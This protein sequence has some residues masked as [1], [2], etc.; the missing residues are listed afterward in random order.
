MKYTILIPGNE[1][2]EEQLIALRGEDSYFKGNIKL[3]KG[4]Y[5]LVPE[6]ERELL[7][8]DN[9]DLQLIGYEGKPK[10]YGTALLSSMGYKAEVLD[11]E[12]KSW[13]NDED[14][15]KV[16]KIADSKGKSTLQHC[17]SREISE[18]DR[19]YAINVLSNMFKIIKEKIK[20]N[21]DYPNKIH[22][23]KAMLGKIK[24]LFI[25]N[26]IKGQ[27]DFLN[28]NTCQS[29][30]I[31]ELLGKLSKDGFEIGEENAEFMK[32]TFTREEYNKM[33]QLYG[34]DYETADEVFSNAF[35]GH[36]LSVIEQ[37]ISKGNSEKN[38]SNEIGEERKSSNL[39]ETA[40]EATE[41]KTRIE[42]INEQQHQIINLEKEKTQI[43]DNREI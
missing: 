37:N 38:N 36:F 40:I 31:N 22:K 34:S 27:S 28:K 16:Y 21:P 32:N 30:G 14:T 25:T 26:V 39:L 9:P 5:I 18:E 11:N 1:I 42:K 15:S 17:Y 41:E 24:N 6:N 3:P 4:A 13:S 7:Q 12:K 20:E 35:V 8:K 43:Q 2:N 10:D 29:E 19:G 33:Q 23:E